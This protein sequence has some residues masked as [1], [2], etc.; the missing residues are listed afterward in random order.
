MNRP[1]L[2]LTSWAV[3]RAS[4]SRAPGDAADPGMCLE[5]TGEA[6]AE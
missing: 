4:S 5:L 6:G 3:E 2:R 1:G